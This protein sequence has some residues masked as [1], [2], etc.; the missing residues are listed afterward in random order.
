MNRSYEGEEPGDLEKDG[1]ITFWMFACKGP[2]YPE[3]E[4]VCT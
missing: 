4:R 2:R 1:L 3:K